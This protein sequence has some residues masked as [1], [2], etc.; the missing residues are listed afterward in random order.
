MFFSEQF[1][2]LNCRNWPQMLNFVVVVLFFFYLVECLQIQTQHQK[3][4]LYRQVPQNIQKIRNSF[5]SNSSPSAFYSCCWPL[6]PCLASA[7]C[8]CHCQTS[9]L[10][11]GFLPTSSQTWSRP[12]LT[13]S[14]WEGTSVTWVWLQLPLVTDNSE[15]ILCFVSRQGI[16]YIL[17][18]RWTVVTLFMGNDCSQ[19]KCYKPSNLM[20]WLISFS[21]EALARG[22]RVRARGRTQRH[23]TANTIQKALIQCYMFFFISSY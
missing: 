18:R 4:V 14:P 22:D 10:R 20:L 16:H 13:A 11:C 9:R 3:A 15:F 8:H 5:L 23:N 1:I 6:R 17:V 21:C 12:Q 7:A 2:W 19:L